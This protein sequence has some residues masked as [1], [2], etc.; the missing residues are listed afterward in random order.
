MV[1]E[2]W[3]SVQLNSGSKHNATH[4]ELRKWNTEMCTEWK[5]KEA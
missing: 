4:V 3:M 5:K 1:K 2:L